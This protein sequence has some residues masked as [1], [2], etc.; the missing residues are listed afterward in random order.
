MEFSLLSFMSVLSTLYSLCVLHFVTISLLPLRSGEV[1]AIKCTRVSES[2]TYPKRAF[3]LPHLNGH[4][5]G[6]RD[7]YAFL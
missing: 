4:Y 7:Y 5:R 1:L 6:S 3:N 2:K